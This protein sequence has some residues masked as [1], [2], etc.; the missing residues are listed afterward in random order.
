MSI[1]NYFDTIS[2]AIEHAGYASSPQ[3]PA[4][5]LS[6]FNDTGW[7]ARSRLDEHVVKA[8]QRHFPGGN[9]VPAVKMIF[10]A[11]GCVQQS[12]VIAEFQR[13][14]QGQRPLRPIDV[15]AIFDSQFMG[16]CIDKVAKELASQ[17]SAK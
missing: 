7:L 4:F 16:Q 12:Q 2:V 13:L 10:G 6:R 1:F 9:G 14:T 5:L 11:L 3:N 17:Q 8:S 15:D